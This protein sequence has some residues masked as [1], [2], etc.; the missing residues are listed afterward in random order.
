MRAS[1]VVFVIAAIGGCLV[2]FLDAWSQAAWFA[3]LI[4]G[5]A[6]V[7]V[8][9]AGASRRWRDVLAVCGGFLAAGLIVGVFRVARGETIDTVVKAAWIYL[10]F[11]GFLGVPAY[12]ATV[13][14]AKVVAWVRT[15]A[16]RRSDPVSV[17]VDESAPEL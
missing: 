10:V 17:P 16:A 15:R 2:A 1:A 6:P 12:L 3:V 5:G 7:G 11:L 13:G 14:L 4:L 8:L 9:A